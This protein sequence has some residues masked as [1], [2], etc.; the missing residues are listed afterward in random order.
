M[1]LHELP[2]ICLG[3]AREIVDGC[4]PDVDLRAHLRIGDDIGY[5]RLSADAAET[6]ELGPDTLLLALVGPEA[7]AYTD[8][9]ELAP[10]LRRSRPGA[11][12][13]ILLG[14]PVAD[15][16]YHRLLGPLAAGSFQVVEAVTVE[17]VQAPLVRAALIVERVTRLLPPRAHLSDAPEDAAPP[18]GD[19]DAELRL[20]LRIANEY[21]LADFAARPMRRRLIELEAAEARLAAAEARVAQSALHADDLDTKL[22]AARAKIAALRSSTRMRV[23]GAVLDGARHPATAPFRVPRDLTRIWRSRRAGQLDADPPR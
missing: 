13:V 21:A 8:P 23:G 16:P 15:L 3:D 14:W 1:R 2:P 19:P 20:V 22:A 12:A 18:A 11:R 4:R 10:L 5:R 17:R 6:L 9:D 7:S